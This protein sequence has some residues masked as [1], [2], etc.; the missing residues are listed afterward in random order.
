VWRFLG[1]WLPR[2]HPDR[3]LRR[4]SPKTR[5]R[6]KIAA[7]AVVLTSPIWVVNMAVAY[8]GRTVV[9]PLS[10]F[11][12]REKVSALGTYAAHRPVCAIFGHPDSGPLVTSAELRYRMP[13]GLL[14]A[15]VQ[16]E[17]GGRPHRISSA[18]AMGPGQLMPDTARRLG[19]RDPFDSEANIDGAARLLSGHLKQFRSVR[20]AVAAYHAGP[21]AVRGGIPQNGLT[22]EYVA[23]VM[24]AYAALRPRR[25]TVTVADRAS[26]R[27]AVGRRAQPRSSTREP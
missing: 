21:G 18:G 10:P 2:L 4:F 12:W 22:P 13:R 7:W 9:F 5:L 17:S 23:R 24:R 26:E 20:L 15:I 3:L 6:I 11:F 19:V 14:A 1:R 16:V 27:G 25:A 8:F